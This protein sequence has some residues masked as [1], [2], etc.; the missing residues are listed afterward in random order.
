MMGYCQN[1]VWVKGEETDVT[2]KMC[3]NYQQLA[4]KQILYQIF[5]T[6]E[7]I[8]WLGQMTPI[9]NGRNEKNRPKKFDLGFT[10][11]FTKPI[12]NINRFVFK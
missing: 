9:L 7:G 2:G 5:K 11:L 3:E 1:A 12:L 4:K 10:K 6:Q 8:A